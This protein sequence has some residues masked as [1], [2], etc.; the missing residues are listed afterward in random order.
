MI[1]VK[2]ASNQ[3]TSMCGYF[4]LKYLEMSSKNLVVV[5]G[6]SGRV[7]SSVDA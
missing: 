5:K 3:D 1:Y 7:R 4:S 2:I 6:V